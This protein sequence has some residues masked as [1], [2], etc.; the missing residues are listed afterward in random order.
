MCLKLLLVLASGTDNVS[1]N[2]LLE[3]LMINSVFESLVSLLSLPDT[4]VNH[5]AAAV[6]VLTLLVQYRKYDS[7]NPY[8]LRLAILDQELSLH[9][10]SQ[11]VTASLATYTR[12]SV[13]LDPT[14][15]RLL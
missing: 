7:S 8:I 15:A 6:T 1:G 3:Y 10:Y 9:G 12:C 5:G 4:R 13:N 11:V 2:T 14:H